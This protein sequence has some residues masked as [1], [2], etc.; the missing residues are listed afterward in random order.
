MRK[1]LVIII[2]AI[3]I[4]IL[5]IVIAA[6][7]IF[8]VN[9][10]NIEGNESYSYDELK[11]ILLDDKYSGNTLYLYYKYKYKSDSEDI[12]FIDK[13]DI[14]IN[15]PS[16]VTFTVYEKDII[17]CFEY[18]GNYMYFDKDGIVVESSAT[19]NE[20]APLISGLSFDYL[21]LGEKLPAENEKN[22]SSIL[23]VTQLLKKYSLVPDKIHFDSKFNVTLF[24]DNARVLLGGDD[25][26]NEKISHLSFIIDNLKDLSGV[27]HMENFTEDTK[28]ISFQKE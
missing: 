20:L 28:N 21:V 27:L 13:V 6:L 5:V 4:I 10:V 3:L 15:S 17:G 12:K 16:E 18:L 19:R 25:Y 1:K 8:K 9:T 11:D 23:N 22:F 14:K 2:P 24:F 7:M 26:L